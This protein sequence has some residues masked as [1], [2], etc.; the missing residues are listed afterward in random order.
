MPCSTLVHCHLTARRFWVCVR[1]AALQ[2]P[3]PTALRQAFVGY[4]NCLI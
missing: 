3:L 2:N 1:V 4:V